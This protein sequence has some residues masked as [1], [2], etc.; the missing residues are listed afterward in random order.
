M[1]FNDKKIEAA[2]TGQLKAPQIR[3]PQIRAPLSR[4]DKA[5]NY[6]ANKWFP[7]SPAT[8]QKLDHIF[9]S[10][11]P[12]TAESRSALSELIR[13]DYS[14]ALFLY[15][16]LCKD[17]RQDL[18]DSPIQ[19]I[20]DTPAEQLIDIIKHSLPILGLHSVEDSE[21]YQLKKLEEAFLAL[22]TT[23]KL[24]SVDSI[25]PDLGAEVSLFRQLG[26]L[27]VAWN[28]PT[29]YHSAV[30]HADEQ[31]S[32]DDNLV[33]ALGFSPTALAMSLAEKWGLSSVFKDAIDS[34]DDSLLAPDET[35]AVAKSISKLCGIGEKLARASN[36][37]V[38]PSAL[39]DWE[40]AKKVITAKLGDDGLKIIDQ[41]MS[42]ECEDLFVTSPFLFKP[43]TISSIE[44]TLRSFELEKTTA[45]N[46]YIS[47][48]GPQMKGELLALYDLIASG[49]KSEQTVALLLQRILPLAGF[50]S[51]A[52]FTLDPGNKKLALQIK[53]GNIQLRDGKNY[54]EFKPKNSQDI[55][56]LAFHSP[57]VLSYDP[58]NPAEP[59][60]LA[61]FFGCSQ[62]FGVFY[63][64]LPSK[65]YIENKS[66]YQGRLKAMVFALNDCLELN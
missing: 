24:C 35:K 60:C 7:C 30:K 14:L 41:A 10:K 44:E 11:T 33:A 27:L 32:I 21:D 38:Y 66:T 13:K 45:R 64:E 5:C 58:K 61:T 26:Y 50:S 28:Y 12:I 36:P 57:E 46:P 51:S 40:D 20:E 42:E 43:G 9:A 6:L 49:Q 34:S 56:P 18:P 17:T 52:L 8:I 53:S 47:D 31:H 37:S 1:G 59:S 29:I 62:R 23:K 2:V 39:H 25:D 4:L 54:Q 3:A 19:L 15:K 65:S 55:V 16:E 22:I 48:C 63:V